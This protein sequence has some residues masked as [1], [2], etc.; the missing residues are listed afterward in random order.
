MEA[1]AFALE[2]LP[3]FSILH[4]ELRNLVLVFDQA[5]SF[6]FAIIFSLAFI[7][8]FMLFFAERVLFVNRFQSQFKIDC[9]IVF[10][11]FFDFVHK[12]EACWEGSIIEFV[13]D[14]V[15]MNLPK[16]DEP[17]VHILSV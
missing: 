9:C 12:C 4:F 15:V 14:D 6:F 10:A 11:C 1:S 3:G 7:A 2:L 17:I 16:F 8:S 5:E 13:E